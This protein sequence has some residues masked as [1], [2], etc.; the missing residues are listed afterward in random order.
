[1]YYPFCLDASEFSATSYPWET[2]TGAEFPFTVAQ[3]DIEAMS[4]DAFKQ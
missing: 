3:M 1:M 4:K 2:I